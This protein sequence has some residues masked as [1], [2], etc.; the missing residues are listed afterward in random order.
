[1]KR[2]V[3]SGYGVNCCFGFGA[4][5]LRTALRS[6]RSGVRFIEELNSY[7]GLHCKIGAKIENVN[8]STIP[9]VN[10]RFM[11]RLAQLGALAA[12]EAR[13]CS[14]MGNDLISRPDMGCI[15]GST[16]GSAQ[17]MDETFRTIIASNNLGEVSG[18][19]FF[20]CASHTVAMNVAQLLGIKGSILSTASACSSSLQSIGLGYQLIR[21][22]IL[23]AAFCG[24]AEELHALAIGSFDSLFAASTSYNDTPQLSPRPFDADRDGLVCGEGAGVLVLESLESALTRGAT[25]HGEVLGYSTCGNTNNI[26]QSDSESITRCIVQALADAGIN[27]DKV[28]YVCAHATGTRQG[29][30]AEAAAIAAVFGNNVPVS[31]LKGALGHTLGA[32]GVIETVASLIMMNEGE[33]YPTVNLDHPSDDCNGIMHVREKLERPIDIF[34]KN[35]FAFGGINAVLVC[36]KY[37][38]T[39]RYL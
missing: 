3:I 38:E 35:S 9:R 36:G 39:K 32:S 20:K 15:M 18:I 13:T 26:S 37:H 17:S 14:E 23:D 34:L 5:V 27:A 12:L 33:I 29:D 21:S 7:N 6:G 30:A 24:G 31:S 2:V 1:M 10:R 25:I 22:G 19:Q 8:V 28:D 16:M 4:E 11:G